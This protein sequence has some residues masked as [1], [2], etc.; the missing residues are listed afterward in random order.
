M[1]SSGKFSL[2]M[3]DYVQFAAASR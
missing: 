2:L 1:R 3:A